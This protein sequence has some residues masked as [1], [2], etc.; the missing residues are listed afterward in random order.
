MLVTNIDNL[1]KDELSELVDL[2]LTKYD[3]E[4]ETNFVWCTQNIKVIHHV[5][6]DSLSVYIDDV[7]SFNIEEI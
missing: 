2:V 4:P 3:G 5:M 1:Y 6:D 7:L